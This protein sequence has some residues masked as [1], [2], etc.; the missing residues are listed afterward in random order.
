MVNGTFL[1]S[2]EWEKFAGRRV[3]KRLLPGSASL[4][5]FHKPLENI[6]FVD[7]HGSR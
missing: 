1:L 3:K 5:D 2:F 7:W 4:P 6:S